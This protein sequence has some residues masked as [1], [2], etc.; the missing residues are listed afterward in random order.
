MGLMSGQKDLSQDGHQP[1]VLVSLR[2]REFLGCDTSSAKTAKAH[3]PL[4]PLLYSCHFFCGLAYYPEHS[5]CAGNIWCTNE[6]GQ[7]SLGQNYWSNTSFPKG[8]TDAPRAS[9]DASVSALSKAKT[10]TSQAASTGMK[11][12][13]HL[14]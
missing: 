12:S 9:R 7:V 11:A 1:M 14:L 6:R 2:P 13:G 8:T 3:I 10:Q 5:R 4:L